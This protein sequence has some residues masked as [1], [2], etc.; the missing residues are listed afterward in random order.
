MKPLFIHRPAGGAPPAGAPVGAGLAAA[1]RKPGVLLA[2]GAAVVVV[3]LAL[4]RKGSGAAATDTTGTGSPYDSTSNDLYNSIQPEIDALAAA[5]AKIQ[6]AQ[7]TPSAPIITTLPGT[8]N[9]H[10]I[11]R[12]APSP[13]PVSRWRPP[14]VYHPV[15]R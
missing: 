7:P 8:V 9:G 14:P 6:G 13:A 5:L 4:A 10:P 12:P 11:P 1:A 2:G 3:V 15:G